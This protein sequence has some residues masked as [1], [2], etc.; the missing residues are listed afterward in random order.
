MGLTL[1]QGKRKKD[2]EWIV[3]IYTQYHASACSERD[4]GC[5]YVR[6]G[7]KKHSDAR[8]IASLVWHTL[9]CA[10]YK[11]RLL[12]EETSGLIHWVNE[13]YTLDTY[14]IINESPKKKRVRK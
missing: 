3:T 2:N 10:G 12:I 14:P 7:G 1:R 6:Y 8:K 4:L 9:Q 11:T 5:T 13:S